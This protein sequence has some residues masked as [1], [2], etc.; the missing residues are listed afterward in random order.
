MAASVRGMPVRAASG[1]VGDL[2]RG[3]RTEALLE[4]GKS[5]RQELPRLG[6]HG[7]AVSGRQGAAPA[8]RSV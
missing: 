5:S 8:H 3:L 7:A 2:S 6:E 4:Q 1:A